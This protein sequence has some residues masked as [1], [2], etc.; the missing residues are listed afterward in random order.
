MKLFFLWALN[1][2]VFIQIHGS[3]EDT[4]TIIV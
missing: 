1:V 2:T 3:T 4:N